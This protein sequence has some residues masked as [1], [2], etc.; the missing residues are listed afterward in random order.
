MSKEMTQEEF[1]NGLMNILGEM[2]ASQ[3]ISI[4]GIYEILA[5]HFN[6]EIIDK[7]EE[8]NYKDE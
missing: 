5:E 6:N 2:K 3:L 8:D 4:P 7:W 1:D